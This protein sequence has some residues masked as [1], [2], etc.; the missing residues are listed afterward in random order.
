MQNTANISGTTFRI[1]HVVNVSSY[2]NSLASEV[3]V[4]IVSNGKIVL[5]YAIG[6]GGIYDGAIEFDGSNTKLFYVTMTEAQAE[7]LRQ[8]M[9]YLEG[10]LKFTDS[11]YPGGRVI[12]F[13]ATITELTKPIS[14]VGN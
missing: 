2:D 9:F 11:N 7:K 10:K 5:K 13:R 14:N 8:G 3:F 1:A 6:G 12:K 4:N